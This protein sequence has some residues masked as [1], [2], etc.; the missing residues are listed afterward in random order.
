LKKENPSL[1]VAD[2]IFSVTDARLSVA[3]K[4]FIDGA[5]G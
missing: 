2:N 5:G 1:S 4:I 3:D